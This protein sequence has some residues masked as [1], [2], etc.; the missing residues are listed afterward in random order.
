MASCSLLLSTAPSVTVCFTALRCGLSRLLSLRLGLLPGTM[1]WHWLPSGRRCEQGSTA[2]VQRGAWGIW[3][4]L[5]PRV[6]CP[7]S[8]V[9]AL[10]SETCHMCNVQGT[11]LWAGASHPHMGRAPIHLGSSCGVNGIQQNVRTYTENAVLV[12]GVFLHFG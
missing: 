11:P 10:S 4:T 5:I 9:A 2:Q 12:Q 7:H 8:W 1:Q 6:W 3:E